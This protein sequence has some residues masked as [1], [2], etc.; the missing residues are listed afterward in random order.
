MLFWGEEGIGV[1]IVINGC[2]YCG[3]IGGVGE[4]VFLLFLGILLVCNVGCNNVGGF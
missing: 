4:V 3:V 1:V 2:L